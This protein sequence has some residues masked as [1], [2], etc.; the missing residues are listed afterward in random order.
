MP[1]EGTFLYDNLVIPSAN[2]KLQGYWLG[3]YNSGSSQPWQLVT[4]G[5]VTSLGE[6]SYIDWAEGNVPYGIALFPNNYWTSGDKY[7]DWKQTGNANGYIV[8]YVA[9][10]PI[11][12]AIWLLG[13]GLAG[14]IGARRK[15]K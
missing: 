5:T 7:Q 13:S 10:V 9:P 15:K 4:G 11:P 12:G 14:L 6:N 3:A 2:S 1:L 8:E